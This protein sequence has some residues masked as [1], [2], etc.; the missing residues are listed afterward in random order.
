MSLQ[1]NTPVECQVRLNPVLDPHGPFELVRAVRTAAPGTATTMAIGFTPSVENPPPISFR[2]D[3][4][5]VLCQDIF[6]N[7]SRFAPFTIY[8][9]QLYLLHEALSTMHFACRLAVGAGERSCE[10]ARER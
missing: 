8:I 5:V 3:V 4:V 2:P 7:S 6:I 9:A 10:K 1:N